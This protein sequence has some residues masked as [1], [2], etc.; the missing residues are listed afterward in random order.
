MNKYRKA[1]LTSQVI[2]FMQ[3]YDS[4][5]TRQAGGK[6]VA[7]CVSS[8]TPHVSFAMLKLMLLCCLVTPTQPELKVRTFFTLLFRSARPA[9]PP[10]SFS[11]IIRATF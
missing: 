6:A 8:H 3:S 2:I 11:Q 9:I 7:I 1:S 4:A 10:D 5:R